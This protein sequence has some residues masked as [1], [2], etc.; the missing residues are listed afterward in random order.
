[1][2]SVSSPNAEA[3]LLQHKAVVAAVRALAPVVTLTTDTHQITF[4][5]TYGHYECE[6]WAH[7][8]KGT[9]DRKWYDDVLDELDRQGE[10]IG[11]AYTDR[12]CNDFPDRFLEA[13]V[14]LEQLF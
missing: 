13:A 11:G 8:I 3:Q 4:T 2:A 10:A 12:T 14:R 6:E 9:A 7:D 1:M 5:W